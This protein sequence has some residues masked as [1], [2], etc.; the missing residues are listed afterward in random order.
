[1][2]EIVYVAAL[3]AGGGLVAA[4][5]LAGG[6]GG[7]ADL[8][9]QADVVGDDLAV[10]ASGFVPFLEFKFW[11]FFAAFFGLTGFLL[12]KVG[13]SELVSFALAL[14]MGLSCGVSI[15][16][17]LDRLKRGQRG[18][19][20]S[21][22]DLLGQEATVRTAI[23]GAVPGEV[24]LLIGGRS[25]DYIAISDSPHRIESGESVVVVAMDDGKLRVLP[26]D[27]LTQ[28]ERV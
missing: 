3:I 23:R 8:D 20:L 24:R 13:V 4:S 2:L 17:A 14:L 19:H 6:F 27:E 9:A 25:I 18:S 16:W 22:D 7:D 15:T 21:I 28:G 1:M 26:K 11:T 5:S 12:L 10:S